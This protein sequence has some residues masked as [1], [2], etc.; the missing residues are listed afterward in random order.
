MGKWTHTIPWDSESLSDISSLMLYLCVSRRYRYRLRDEVVN[1]QFLV[2][3]I[4]ERELAQAEEYDRVQEYLDTSDSSSNYGSLN[5][6]L[7][8]KIIVP[9]FF[10]VMSNNV[11]PI[12]PVLYSIPTGCH[13]W[14]KF[15]LICLCVYTSACSLVYLFLVNLIGYCMPK[16]C[17]YVGKHCSAFSTCWKALFSDLTAFAIFF[18]H[19]SS[20]ISPFGA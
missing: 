5:Q 2:E 8:Q 14:L 9:L 12:Y 1:E 18:R 3:E 19:W 15:I 6:W 13:F 10:F 4:Y 11:L 17:L 16:R 20:N 7:L